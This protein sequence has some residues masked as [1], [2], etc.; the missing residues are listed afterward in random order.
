FYFSPPGKRLPPSLFLLPPHPE[1]ISGSR[2]TLSLTCLAR[3]F[4]PENIDIRWQKNQELL[5][6]NPGS[7]SFPTGS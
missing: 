7:A 1:E 5:P 3:G 2:P 6:E 4:F